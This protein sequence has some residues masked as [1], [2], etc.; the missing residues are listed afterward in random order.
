[1]N[2]KILYGCVLGLYTS[3][4]I[5]SDCCPKY[6][7]GKDLTD[8]GSDEGYDNSTFKKSMEKIQQDFNSK[9][10]KITLKGQ[11]DNEE[12]EKKMRQLNEQYKL[13]E[14]EHKKKI[15]ENADTHQKIMEQEKERHE[16]VNKEED[17][18]TKIFRFDIALK[19]L[20]DR[21]NELIEIYNMTMG[22]YKEGLAKPEHY[23]ILKD[24]YS[25]YC[26]KFNEVLECA[27]NASYYKYENAINFIEKYKNAADYFGTGLFITIKA[28]ISDYDTNLKNYAVNIEEFKKDLNSLKNL[29]NK[30]LNS[31]KILIDNNKDNHIT[32]I[33]CDKNFKNLYSQ[34]KNS[35]NKVFGEAQFLQIYC[36]EAYNFLSSVSFVISFDLYIDKKEK[37]IKEVIKNYEAICKKE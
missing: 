29:K 19:S 37:D 16:Q 8:L 4:T 9:M 25:K 26:N 21:K 18:K 31:Y 27:N 3:N 35:F 24:R 13:G 7:Q 22:Y 6:D 5:F 36:D 17:N 2:I 32:K 12:F 30:L 11:L 15:K 1:M 23:I 20:G 14:E 28:N 10:D 34:C 33:I